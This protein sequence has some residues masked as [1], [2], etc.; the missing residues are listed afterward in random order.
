MKQI[1]LFLFVLVFSALSAQ[2]G[3]AAEVFGPNSRW[4]DNFGKSWDLSGAPCLGGNG[5]CVT[6]AR[7]IE[8]TLGCGALPLRGLETITNR[9]VNVIT[10]TVFSRSPRCAV[11]TWFA[12]YDIVSGS[13][14][15]FVWN[16]DGKRVPFALYRE[17][18]LRQRRSLNAPS[19]PSLHISR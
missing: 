12:S 2:V 13:F 5:S 19:D 9:N 4:I 14:Q 16:N 10:F 17:A 18:P 3:M 7:D 15:G 1:Q 8:S 6:G 11:S